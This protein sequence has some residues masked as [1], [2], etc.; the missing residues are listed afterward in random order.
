MVRKWKH[1]KWETN[2]I[3][4]IIQKSSNF[5]AQDKIRNNILGPEENKMMAPQAVG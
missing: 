1:G 5:L 4:K 3:K 2:C